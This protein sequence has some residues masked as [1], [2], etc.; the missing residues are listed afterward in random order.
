MIGRR[1]RW[2][3]LDIRILPVHWQ[4][5]STEIGE[6]AR[7]RWCWS[8]GSKGNT[9][10]GSKKR[11]RRRDVSDRC[12]S[13][14]ALNPRPTWTRI[15]EVEANG[16]KKTRRKGNSRVSWPYRVSPSDV[17]NETRDYKSIRFRELF[18]YCKYLSCTII[19]SKTSIGE[20]YAFSS[21]VNRNFFPRIVVFIFIRK[22]LWFYRLVYFNRMI[23]TMKIENSWYMIMYIKY[24]NLSFL[25]S[26][27]YLLIIY[28]LC[29]RII[30]ILRK[31]SHI[32]F[33]YCKQGWETLIYDNLHRI[34]WNL[35]LFV[36]IQRNIF[37]K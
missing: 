29:N 34:N 30:K 35:K 21:L 4:L 11:G 17:H 26:T 27:E 9:C 8:V 5:L 10:R 36:S 20:K 23:E 32:L 12:A 13:E 18:T 14:C 2:K 25:I 6:R 37:V 22:N 28:R 24:F 3:T 31:E 7:W 15:Y 1:I 19:Y 33:D 16:K